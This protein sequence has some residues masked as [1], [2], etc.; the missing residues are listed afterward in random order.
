MKN[1]NLTGAL[2]E[3]E[4]Q[5]FNHILE[6]RIVERGIREEYILDLFPRKDT[7]LSFDFV[8]DDQGEIT[9]YSQQYD[10]EYKVYIH[11]VPE[12]LFGTTYC[13]L[14][15]GDLIIRKIFDLNKHLERHLIGDM[16]TGQ[17]K[18]CPEEFRIYANEPKSN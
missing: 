10:Q 18:T 3:L 16:R 14:V 1:P 2:T 4:A 9:L 17:F 15:R 12:H 11:P 13:D 6:R 5:E 8:Q 7:V